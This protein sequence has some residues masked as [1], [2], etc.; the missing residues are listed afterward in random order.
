MYR[1]LTALF[2]AL[3][4][5]RRE[6]DCTPP[7]TKKFKECHNS[8]P[9]TRKTPHFLPFYWRKV[10]RT[11]PTTLHFVELLM[12]SV[13]LPNRWSL[14]APLSHWSNKE[15]KQKKIFR[16]FQSVRLTGGLKKVQVMLS[17][18]WLIFYWYWPRSLQL[19]LAVARTGESWPLLVCDQKLV[20]SSWKYIKLKC[21]GVLYVSVKALI[22]CC[23]LWN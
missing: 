15:R 20:Y 12:L 18:G 2:L 9:F 3:K 23:V 5:P 21:S 13:K 6:A 4:R 17:K 22:F 11:Y 8:T 14:F 1:V 19:T 7:S 16:G 10:H